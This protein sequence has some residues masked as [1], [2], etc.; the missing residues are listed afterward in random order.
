MNILPSILLALITDYFRKKKY[1]FLTSSKFI[2]RLF[3][4]H[5]VWLY[6]KE[7]SGILGVVGKRSGNAI[8]YYNKGLQCTT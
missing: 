5:Q 1:F 8:H 2:H 6:D 4:E 7:I 3:N